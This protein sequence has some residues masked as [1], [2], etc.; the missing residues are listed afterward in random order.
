MVDRRRAV[1][2]EA[3]GSLDVISESDFLFS[4]LFPC[5]IQVTWPYDDD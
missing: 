5:A 1:G 3:R 4:S 2:E